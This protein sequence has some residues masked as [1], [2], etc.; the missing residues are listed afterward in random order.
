MNRYVNML[1]QIQE[2]EI[3]L[4][5]K[6]LMME[7]VESKN[8]ALEEL[9]Y[10]ISGLKKELPFEVV[11]PFERIFNKHGLA[12]CPMIN[13]TCTG[14]SMKLPVGFANNVLSDKNCISCPNCGRY[15]FY[16][17]QLPERPGEEIKQYKGVARFSSL[18]LM[19]P[20][21]EAGKKEDIER[22]RYRR[23][24]A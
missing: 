23:A 20:N 17:E 4:K 16:D 3:V 15:L 24:G 13:S 22:K 5:E 10:D 12:V 7:T 1:L 6:N 14:C 21:V 8:K 19:C 2:L 18:E 11:S 9:C